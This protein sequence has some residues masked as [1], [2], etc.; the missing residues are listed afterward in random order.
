LK[1]ENREE[2]NSRR[3]GKSDCCIRISLPVL[4]GDIAFMLTPV[5]FYTCSFTVSD[6]NKK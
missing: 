1:Q 5:P 2:E 4:S 6:R 3:R